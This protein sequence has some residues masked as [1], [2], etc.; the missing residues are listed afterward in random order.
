MPYIEIGTD[1]SFLPVQVLAT[2]GEIEKLKKCRIVKDSRT[3][4]EIQRD[5][6]FGF[7]SEIS[8][9]NQ[10]RFSICSVEIEV[11]GKKIDIWNE[12]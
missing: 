7:L 3:S 5:R 2:N 11:D 9:A 10:T 4:I 8:T 12:D 1:T 6:L